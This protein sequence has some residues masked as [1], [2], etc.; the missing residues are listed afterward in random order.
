MD[1]LSF[2]IDVFNVIKN[3]NFALINHLYA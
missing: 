1:I 3:V 2:N